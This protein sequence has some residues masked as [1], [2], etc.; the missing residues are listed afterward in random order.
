MIAGTDYAVR[1]GIAWTE[2]RD[3]WGLPI[4]YFAPIPDG[5]ISVLPD[6]AALIWLAA[7]EGDHP[8]VEEVALATG[9]PVEAIREDV[10]RFLAEL[11]ERGLLRPAQD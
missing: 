6:M 9:H 10:E 7:V 1:P 2:A 8:A 5:P 4:V 11:V 3:V